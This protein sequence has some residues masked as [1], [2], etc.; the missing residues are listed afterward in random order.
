VFAKPAVRLGF[1][2]VL[3]GWLGGRLVIRGAGALG[4]AG[5]VLLEVGKG[6]SEEAFAKPGLG[7]RVACVLG[8]GCECGTTRFRVSTIA[9]GGSSDA[10]VFA[11]PPA[12]LFFCVC[13]AIWGV[14]DGRGC[15]EV[16]VE[17]GSGRR[18]G[19]FVNPALVRFLVDISFLV[20]GALFGWVG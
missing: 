14:V 10:H 17:R 19:A 16:V 15:V 18:D 4:L 9:G 1:G 20:S 7:L 6:T 11:I 5:W 12:L 2:G 3:I 8:V 13:C